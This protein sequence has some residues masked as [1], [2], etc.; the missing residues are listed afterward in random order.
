LGRNRA[1]GGRNNKTYKKAPVLQVQ[2]GGRIDRGT[3]SGLSMP[4]G[5]APQRVLTHTGAVSGA[6][7][8]PY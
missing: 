5:D 4:R 3:T 2:D 1:V 7:V 6:P 8:C